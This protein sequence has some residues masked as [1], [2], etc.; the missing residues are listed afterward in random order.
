MDSFTA[1][2]EKTSIPRLFVHRRMPQQRRRRIR[3]RPRNTCLNAWMRLGAPSTITRV[4]ELSFPQRS[5]SRVKAP[6]SPCRSPTRIHKDFLTGG[7]R[8]LL[9]NA[10]S[11]SRVVLV[12]PP[13]AQST[14]GIC[15]RNARILARGRV[16]RWA[17][18]KAR[19]TSIALGM[20]FPRELSAKEQPLNP[21][22]P[23]RGAAATITA[24]SHRV[25][26]LSLSLS[27]SLARS[28]S[29]FSLWPD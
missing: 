28:F 18:E 22:L 20:K 4:I 13:S 24:E 7:E 25:S 2:N 6:L 26:P 3:I 10:R 27:L 5:R 1:S 15:T 17:S 11:V 16:R 23:S 8:D 14:T 19:R 21:A 9:R 12:R 29:P